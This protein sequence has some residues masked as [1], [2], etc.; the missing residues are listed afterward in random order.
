MVSPASGR[1]LARRATRQAVV[2][3]HVGGWGD[4]GGVKA[5]VAP[6]QSRMT[7]R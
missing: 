2:P 1:A 6:I 7:N 5:V 4:L 3:T